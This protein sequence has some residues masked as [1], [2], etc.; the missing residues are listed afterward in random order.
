MH[1]NRTQVKL[2]RYAKICIIQFCRQMKLNFDFAWL[3]IGKIKTV[4]FFRLPSHK[5]IKILS[6]CDDD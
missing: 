1:I 2:L 4:E 5:I 3:Q 6:M